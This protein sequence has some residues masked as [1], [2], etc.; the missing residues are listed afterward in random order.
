MLGQQRTACNAGVWLAIENDVF[1]DFVGHQQHAGIA[2]DGFQ[3]VQVAFFKDRAGGIVREV[4]HQQA[5]LGR[6]GVAHTLPIDAVVGIGLGG[7]AQRHRHGRATGQTDRRQVGVVAGF[8]DD[9]FV[10]AIDRGQHG[11]HQGLG[12][13]AGD[14]DLG[15]W[16]VGMAIEFARLGG[17]GVAQGGNPGHV[18]ILVVAVGHRAGHE[19][20]QRGVWI[21]VRK[22]L[23][24]VDG[25][26][27]DGQAAHHGEDGGADVGK[28]G[29][30]HGGREDERW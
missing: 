2:H 29:S 6:D 15:F 11:R 21:E 24:Q 14:G 22:A 10:A 18:G 30:D 8:D 20:A 13:P 9:H 23:A 3:S 19:R 4:E 27:F 17:D 7:R 1:I 12:G 5:R 28:F 25:L 26:V 16:I